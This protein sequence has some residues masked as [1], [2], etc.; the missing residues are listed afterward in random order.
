MIYEE[1][2]QGVYSY[3]LL[4]EIFFT[5]DHREMNQRTNEDLSLGR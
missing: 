5:S 3:I 2:V 4:S 1:S